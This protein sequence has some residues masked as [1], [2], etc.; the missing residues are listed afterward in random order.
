MEKNNLRECLVHGT[1]TFPFAIY[2]NTFEKQYS[3]LAPLH[4]HNEFELLIATKG[5]IRVQIKDNSYTLSEGEGVFINSGLLHMIRSN[6]DTTH[7]FI[8]IVFD[9]SILCTEHDSTFNKYIQPLINGTLVVSTMLSSSLCSMIRSICTAYE[10]ASFGYELY[11]K[12]SLLQIFHLLL[13]NSE[14]TTLP[15]PNTKIIIIKNVMDYVKENYSE[16]ISLQDLADHV[17][18]SKEYLCRVFTIMSDNSPVEYL[19]RYRIR[20]SADMLIH[21][22]KSI[23]DIAL[24]CGFNNSSYYNKLFLRYLGYTP[25]EYRKLNTYSDTN[26]GCHTKF[27]M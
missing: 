21:T 24:S 7:G 17:H 23:S 14:P 8:A 20:Q 19:N 5:S 2:N 6:D 9:F 15:V 3:L 1:P 26:W 27:D 22:D 16:Q 13:Q 18:I 10:N 12:H 11:I 4:Y 25:S